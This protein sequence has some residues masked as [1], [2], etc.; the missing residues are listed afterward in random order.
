MSKG[1]S[2]ERVE[3]RAGRGMESLVVMVRAYTEKAKRVIEI[4]KN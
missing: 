3:V 4:C 2:I 1:R